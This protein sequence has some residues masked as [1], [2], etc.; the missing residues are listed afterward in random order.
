MSSPNARRRRLPTRLRAIRRST[1]SGR[2]GAFVPAV[3]PSSGHPPR[4]AGVAFDGPPNPPGH[5][6]AVIGAR[7]RGDL[8]V[9]EVGGV[10]AA[11]IE[12]D[13]IPELL[14]SLHGL[15]VMP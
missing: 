6:T 4:G 11:R 9:A 3:R 2:P 7:L 10:Y 1:G 12:G 15:P 13:V 5:P 8:L 14:E